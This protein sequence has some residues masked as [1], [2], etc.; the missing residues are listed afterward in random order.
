MAEIN[1]DR[2]FK[3]KKS[4]PQF[5]T[6]PRFPAVHR[7]MALLVPEDVQ[8]ADIVAVLKQAGGDLLKSIS[9][10]DV[11]QGKQVE[12]GKKSVAFAFVFKLTG[13]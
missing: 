10:F 2:L 11:Y 4:E 12:T 6:L 8:V 5:H 3:Y 7:D 13:H 9:I 1:L